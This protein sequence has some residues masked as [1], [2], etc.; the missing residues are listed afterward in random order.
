MSFYKT[1][2]FSSTEILP[3]Y[4]VLRRHS[5]FIQGIAERNSVCRRRCFACEP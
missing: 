1:T 5:A 4:Q 2:F 3:V